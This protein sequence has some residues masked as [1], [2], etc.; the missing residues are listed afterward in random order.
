MCRNVIL[1]DTH[2]G[3]NAVVVNCGKVWNTKQVKHGHLGI[4]VGPES[5]GGRNLFIS[6]ES[7]MIDISEDL[8]HLQR[9]PCGTNE[10]ESACDC[11]IIGLNAV[12]RD[13]STVKNVYLSPYSNILT[14]TSVS[15]VVLL[16]YSEIS[17]GSIVSN[18]MLQWNASISANSN[19][20]QTL[21][22]EHTCSRRST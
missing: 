1:S 15:N 20:S 10:D 21:L 13:T 4:T 2:V 6:P 19:V 17:D 8:Q 3:E 22:M 11:N 18:V 16:P 7:T 9:Q 14:A 5:G 12:V